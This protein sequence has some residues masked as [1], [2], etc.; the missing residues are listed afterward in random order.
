MFE[1]Q[2]ASRA[3]AGGGAQNNVHSTVDALLHKYGRH[4]QIPSAQ[5][6]VSRKGLAPIKWGYDKNNIPGHDPNFTPLNTKKP[7]GK[8]EDQDG[9]EHHG[10]PIGPQDAEHKTEVGKKSRGSPLD[11]GRRRSKWKKD[12]YRKLPIVLDCSPQ[13]AAA[14][15]ARR[16]HWWWKR[17]RSARWR[18]QG[19]APVLD[20][21][22]H[23]RAPFGFVH[24]IAY[25][26]GNSNPPPHDKKVRL[27][28]ST[29]LEVPRT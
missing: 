28:T 2:I 21:N 3:L 24:S 14:N 26:I 5:Q 23:D 9:Q 6:L 11:R 13:E 16:S 15:S 29:R 12:V 1:S 25:P 20:C 7:R 18:I 10:A 19:E 27:P 17:A 8:L 4:E 22:D